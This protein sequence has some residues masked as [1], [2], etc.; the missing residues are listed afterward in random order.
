MQIIGLLCKIRKRNTS[1]EYNMSPLTISISRAMFPEKSNLDDKD[2]N[3]KMAI[4]N[5]F[6]KLE[7]P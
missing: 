6:K 5:M 3:F 7:V 2:N 4:V 1:N